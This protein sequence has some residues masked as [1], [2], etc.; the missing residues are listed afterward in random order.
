MMVSRQKDI[1]EKMLQWLLLCSLNRECIIPFGHHPFCDYNVNKPYNK[2]PKE[3]TAGC[4][5]YDQAIINVLL[6]NH[7][8]FDTNSYTFSGDSCFEVA[9]WAM[10]PDNISYC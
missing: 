7:F 9:K 8:T 6:A 2:Q 10:M 4:H 1:V 3:H 5:L